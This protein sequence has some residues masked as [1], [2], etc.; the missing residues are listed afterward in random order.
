MSTQ[1]FEQL[2]TGGHPNSLGNTVQVVEMVLEN[3]ENLEEFYQC[4]FSKD[5]VVRLRVSNGMKRIAAANYQL[6]LPY[7]EQFISKISTINQASTQWTFAQLMLTYRKDLSELQLQK[8]TEIIQ[9]NLTHSDDWI[10][11]IQSMKTLSVF[12]KKDVKL[13]SWLKPVLLKLSHDSRNSVSK[14]AR[15]LLE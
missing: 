11:L 13:Q 1:K 5:E 9:S 3:P 14:N 2:L 4:Y 8:A 12:A 7:L 15:K 10:V 6:L